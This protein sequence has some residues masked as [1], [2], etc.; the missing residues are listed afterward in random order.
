MFAGIGA[1][2]IISPVGNLADKLLRFAGQEPQHSLQQH[3][4]HMGK[5][6]L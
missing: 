3:L 4:T 2:D 5:P 6:D 1:N